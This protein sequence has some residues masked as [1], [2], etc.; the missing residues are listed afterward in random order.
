MNE[1]K[2]SRHA[3]QLRPLSTEA[4]DSLRSLGVLKRFRGKSSRNDVKSGGRFPILP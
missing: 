3:Y 1:F 4:W 2:S